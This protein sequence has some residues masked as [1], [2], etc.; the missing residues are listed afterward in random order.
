[1]AAKC[2]ASGRNDGFCAGVVLVGLKGGEGDGFLL[3]GLL[4]FCFFDIFFF[5]FLDQLLDQF[6]DG[7][8]ALGG[9]GEFCARG[10]YSQL[11]VDGDLFYRLGDGGCEAGFALGFGEVEAG[12]LEAVE[13]EAGAAGVDVVGGDSLEDLADGVLDGGAV[14]GEREFEGGAAGLR[15]KE[16]GC[17]RCLDDSW[18]HANTHAR[19]E[20]P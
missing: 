16:H 9:V 6:R 15:Q 20:L 12:D 1:M 14:F 17:P 18:C 4:S 5:G 19:S 13:E 10:Y 11:R 7:A 2:A 3:G 8:F